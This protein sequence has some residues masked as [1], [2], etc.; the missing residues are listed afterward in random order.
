MGVGVT[1]N[2]PEIQEN[3]YPIDHPLDKTI[4]IHAFGGAIVDAPNGQKQA[5]FPSKIY[6]YFTEVVAILKPAL[7]PL[8][9][10]LYQIGAPGEPP[11]KGLEQLTGRT[12]ILQCTYLV[13][14]CALLIANDSLWSHERGIFDKSLVAIYG[15]TSKP[16]FPYWKNPEKTILIESHRFGKKPSF[17]SQE[18]VK[19]INLITPESIANAAFSLLGQPQINQQSLTMGPYFQ[20]SIIEI[21]PDV[22]VDPKIQFGV[23]PIIRMD[24]CFNEDNLSKNLSLKKSLIITNREIYINILTRFR[25]NIDSIRVEIDKVS[26]EWLRKVKKLGFKWGV[27]AVEKDPE[28]IIK[29]RLDY[30]DALQPTSFDLFVAPTLDDWKK[31]VEKYTQKPLDNTIKLDTL[32]FKSN[33]F[34]L[35]EGKIYLSKAHWM[36]KK[37]TKS[38][39]DNIGN[40]IDVPEF[41][42][43]A[44]HFYIYK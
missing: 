20:Q 34:L 11:V 35:S 33:K 24:L 40:V 31:E 18:P 28:K 29:M 38:T 25:S 32:F 13:K 9:Y 39:D 21:I 7:E 23:P 43:E 36:A 37:P 5:S 14:R 15:P 1:L 41:W 42:E 30:Y 16:H 19:T 3:Y 2:R 6:D 10:K 12:S 17:S 8:G 22:V 27:M 4:L 44:S 26:P